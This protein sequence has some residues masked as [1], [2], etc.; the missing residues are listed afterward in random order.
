MQGEFLLWGINSLGEGASGEIGNCSAMPK[1][2]SRRG[3]RSNVQPEK[4]ALPQAG[5]SRS[6]AASAGSRRCRCSLPLQSLPVKKLSG[7]CAAGITSFA[8]GRDFPQRRRICRKRALLLQ[9]AV[10]PLPVKRQ[11]GKCAAEKPTFAAGRDFPQRRCIRRKQALPLQSA[12][13]PFP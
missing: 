2:P 13:T 9:S 12:V 1:A 5:I 6:T 8:V 4:P 10:T 3:S 11:S 7:K